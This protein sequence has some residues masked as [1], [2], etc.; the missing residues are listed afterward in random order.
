MADGDVQDKV[1]TC[2]KMHSSGIGGKK[3]TIHT[4]VDAGEEVIKDK[5]FANI[6]EAPAGA[7]GRHD[8]DGVGERQHHQHSCMA[9]RSLAVVV[10]VVARLPEDDAVGQEHEE[11]V[12]DDQDRVAIVCLALISVVVDSITTV[13]LVCPS[14]KCV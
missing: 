4:P 6:P 5:L 10:E 7:H 8:A 9:T 1:D 2:E 13:H 12:D 11:E 14:G 3:L